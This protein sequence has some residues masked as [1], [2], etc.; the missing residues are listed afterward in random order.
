M[1]LAYIGKAIE[2]AEYKR[3][4]DNSWFAEIPD[5]P[6]VWANGVTVEA[7]RQELLEVLEEWLLLKLRDRDPIPLAD[8]MTWVR[9]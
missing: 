4:E 9:C 1:L 7:C 5:F 6:G 8:T 3:L 2:K